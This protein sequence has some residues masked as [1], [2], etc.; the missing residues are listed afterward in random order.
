M[1]IQFLKSR[2]VILRDADIYYN[3]AKHLGLIYNALQLNRRD[4]VRPD[5]VVIVGYPKS[6]NTWFQNIIAATVYG[7]NLQETPLDVVNILVPDINLPVFHRYTEQPMYF[8]SHL[9]PQPAYRKVVYLVRDGRDAMISFYHYLQGLDHNVTLQQLVDI[10]TEEHGKWQDH[11]AAWYD[12]P[13][14]AQM[15][16]IRYEDLLDDM[17]QELKRFCDFIGIKRDENALK[18]V[19][20]VTS[21]DNMRKREDRFGFQQYRSEQNFMR[22]GRKGDF[23]N[24][25]PLHVLTTF[26]KQAGKWLEHL[27]YPLVDVSDPDY[28]MA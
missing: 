24:E 15:I 5:D 14:E 23:H 7:I 1:V 13:Y 20:S 9:L 16:T 22:R 6:G 8:K 21:F 19:Q 4:D 3:K 12:N 18:Q 17:L 10:G 11:V 26:Q 2:F 28:Q 25:M 27:G